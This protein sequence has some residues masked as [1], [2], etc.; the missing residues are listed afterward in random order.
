M[1]Q[2]GNAQTEMQDQW[3][4][5]AGQDHRYRMQASQGALDRNQLGTASTQQ[6]QE[7]RCT[8][9][10]DSESP[11]Q[12]HSLRK[13]SPLRKEGSS[14]DQFGFGTA[15]RDKG[16]THSLQSLGCTLRVHIATPR[17]AH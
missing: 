6:R 3:R 4:C 1:S 9:L 13:T 2:Q 12:P 16:C 5:S 15:Q 14:F 17:T 8:S 10:P 7:R 11:Q